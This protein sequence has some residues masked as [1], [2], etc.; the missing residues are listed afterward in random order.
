MIPYYFEALA[1]ETR[2]LGA[3]TTDRNGLTYVFRGKSLTLDEAVIGA[4]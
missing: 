3:I 1:S 4:T 2:V